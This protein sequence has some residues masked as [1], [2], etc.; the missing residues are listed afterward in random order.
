[1]AELGFAAAPAMA[2]YDTFEAAAGE[3]IVF[4]AMYS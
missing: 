2:T 3:A 4:W 1:V